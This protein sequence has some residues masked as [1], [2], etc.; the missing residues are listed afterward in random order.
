M[1]NHA[2]LP[3]FRDFYPADFAVRTHIA[4]AWREA[5]IRHAF[6]EYDGPP[7]E[8]LEL[9]TDKSGEEI[10][11][12]LYHFV[13]KGGRAVALRP[14]MTPT[15]ARMV[16]TRAGALRKPIRWFSIPQLFRYERTQRGRL[17]E[18]F[19]WNVDVIGEQDAGADAEVLA[20]ALDGLALLGLGPDAVIARFNDR[21]L[22]EALL[23]HLGVGRDRL[24]GTYSAVDKLGREPHEQIIRK[25]RDAGLPPERA[26]A[27]LA[28]FDEPGMDTLSARWGDVAGVGAVLEQLDRYRSCLADMGHGGS[29][30]FDLSIVRG[31][32]YYTG[33]VFEIFDRAGALRAICGG[34]RYD[35][36]LASV[37]RADLPAVG[38]GMGDV[39]LTELLQERGLVPRY[40]VRV[41][42]FV[43]AIGEAQRAMQ[44]RVATRLRA[45]GRSVAY[46]LADATVA[47]QF[48]DAHA[49]GAGR[50]I[51][52]GPTEVEEG[53]VVVKEMASGVERRVS[54]DALLAGS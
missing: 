49:H 50:A 24:A 35:R 12:Q 28:L 15:L 46:A 27:V 31:L 32:A 34:G 9:Y 18:H 2:S 30:L 29:I 36:L 21:R 5:S 17:R 19:Q 38:F 54:L 39:V 42:D 47:R 45:A 33:T 52:I 16:G 25:L 26:A 6:E 48:K 7:L 4:N 41:D 43:I 8:S 20:T 40:A 1:S 44:R 23:L 37:S 13:D 22:L 10:T 51:V 14:E 3:G 53:V 11:G